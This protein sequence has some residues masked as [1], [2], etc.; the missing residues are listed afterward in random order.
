MEPTRAHPLP[1][2][3][4]GGKSPTIPSKDVTTC[5]H[6]LVTKFI[7]DRRTRGLSVN[8]LN[9]YQGY[10][11]SFTSRVKH[12]VTA[13]QKNDIAVFLDS[14]TCQQGGKHAYYRCIRAFYNW[15]EDEGIV[16]VNPI[17]R[18]KAPKVPKPTRVKV[19]IN[20]LDTLLENCV[21]LRDK[22]I[23]L[24]LIDTGLRRSELASINVEDVD[25]ITD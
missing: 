22:V 13:L 16:E 10:L 7:S 12:V 25:T 2:H 4:T 17:Q 11:N 15:L 6:F 5:N 21:Y 23:I 1:R 24:M 9:F 3:N 18:M 19:D 20:S 14:L 8:T